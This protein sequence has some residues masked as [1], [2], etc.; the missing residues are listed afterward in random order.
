MTNRFQIDLR[1]YIKG[2]TKGVYNIGAHEERTVLSVATDICSRLGR[3]VQ[4]DTC[5]QS[6]WCQLWH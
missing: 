5:V 3:A 1:R 6:A 4:V 2:A